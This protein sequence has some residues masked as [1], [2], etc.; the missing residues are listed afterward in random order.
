MSAIK[1][2][3]VFY[4]NYTGHPVFIQLMDEAKYNEFKGWQPNDSRIHASTIHSDSTRED[5][6]IITIIAV[7]EHKKLGQKNAEIVDQ[8]VINWLMENGHM[9]MRPGQ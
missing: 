8:E 5:D 4:A 3:Y 9:R 7:T 2:L 6:P 1:T